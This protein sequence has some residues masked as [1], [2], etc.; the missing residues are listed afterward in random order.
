MSDQEIYPG[1]KAVAAPIF[2]FGGKVMASI[3]VAGPRERLTQEKVTSL[4]NY[5]LKAS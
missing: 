3:C 1:V 4:I 5:V 2:D